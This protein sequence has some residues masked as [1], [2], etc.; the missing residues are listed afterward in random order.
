MLA[1]FAAGLSALQGH[2]STRAAFDI[3]PRPAAGARP[4]CETHCPRGAGK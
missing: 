3:R 2:R 4:A 1:R